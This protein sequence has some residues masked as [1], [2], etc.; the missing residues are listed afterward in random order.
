ML[1]GKTLPTAS[2]LQESRSHFCNSHVPCGQKSHAASP[3]YNVEIHI[4]SRN[5]AIHP[6]VHQVG[7]VGGFCGSIRCLHDKVSVFAGMA[8]HGVPDN[9]RDERPC[10]TQEHQQQDAQNGGQVEVWNRA[11]QRV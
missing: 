1:W 3:W 6:G 7:I 9:F 2:W 5:S 11:G 8:I 4:S 10:T